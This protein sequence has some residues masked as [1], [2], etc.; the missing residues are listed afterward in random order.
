MTAPAPSGPFFI[1]GV[2]RFYALPKVADLKN[3]T[4]A[5][6]AAG[7][8]LK[9]IVGI[10]GFSLTRSFLPTPDLDSAFTG[11]VSGELSAG[12]CSLTFKDIRGDST[13]RDVLDDDTSLVL[14]KMDYGDIPGDR[15]ECWP[16]ISGGVNQQVDL[17]SYGQYKVDFSVPEPP[18]KNAVIPART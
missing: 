9:N 4:R 7:V 1:R 10:G 5:E 12:D 14:M 6:I 13:N 18:E 15:G 8:W 11:N 2:T 16:V 3:P 17:A